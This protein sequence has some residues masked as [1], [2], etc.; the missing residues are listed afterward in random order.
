MKMLL[1]HN[2]SHNWFPVRDIIILLK[3][4]IQTI[5]LCLSLL[6]K[7]F[8]MKWTNLIVFGFILNSIG[9]IIIFQSLHNGKIYQ[10]QKRDNIFG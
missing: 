8:E 3:C 7:R 4:E 10:K 5:H 6:S 1:M 9:Y 2:M